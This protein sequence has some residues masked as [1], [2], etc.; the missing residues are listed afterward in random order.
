MKTRAALVYSGV[1]AS[2]YRWKYSEEIMCESRD[3]GVECKCG[4]RNNASGGGRCRGIG[5]QEA[6]LGARM[7]TRE[8]SDGRIAQGCISQTAPRLPSR[9]RRRSPHPKAQ[10]NIS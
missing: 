10:H 9:T 2:T 1:W 5:Q 6:A 7:T 3:N 8:K 4:R